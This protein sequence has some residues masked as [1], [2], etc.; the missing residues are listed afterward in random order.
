MFK[1]PLWSAIE[2]TLL[3]YSGNMYNRVSLEGSVFTIQFL[4]DKIHN[5]VKKNIIVNLIIKKL[6]IKHTSFKRYTSGQN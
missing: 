2:T 4:N 5:Y 6:K 1:K 3:H